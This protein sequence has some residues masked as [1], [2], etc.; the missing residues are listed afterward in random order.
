MQALRRGRA[1]SAADQSVKE[2]TQNDA[3]GLD[4]ERA[5]GATRRRRTM[6]AALL[7]IVAIVVALAVVL[8]V[9]LAQPSY[10][11]EAPASYCTGAYRW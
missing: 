1:Y 7:V 4:D 11:L 5:V 8:G 3:N 10:A 2:A 9:F 6:V